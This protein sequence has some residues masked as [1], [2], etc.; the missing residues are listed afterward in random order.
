M[1]DGNFRLSTK[2]LVNRPVTS[3]TTKEKNSHTLKSVDLPVKILLQKP[4]ESL[5]FFSPSQKPVLLSWFCINISLFQTPTFGFAWPHCIQPT[6]ST[7]LALQLGADL[8]RSRHWKNSAGLLVDLCLLLSL[9]L[10]C[11]V[12][13]PCGNWDLSFPIRN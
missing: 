4:L 1:E 11:F 6:N 7:A 12:F 13:Q 10:F 3:P 5:G 8:I 2:S 9:L